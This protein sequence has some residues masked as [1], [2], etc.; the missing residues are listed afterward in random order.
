MP[1]ARSSD[2]DG[3]GTALGV[4]VR[5]KLSMAN[6]VMSTESLGSKIST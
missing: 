1:V 3:S 2:E 4:G 5:I 6:G